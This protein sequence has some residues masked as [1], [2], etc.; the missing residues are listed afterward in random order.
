MM[1]HSW[2]IKDEDG[3]FVVTFDIPGSEVN[4]LNQDNLSELKDIVTSLSENPSVK[5]V[6]FRSAKKKIFIA[7]A[8]IKLIESVRTQDDGFQKAEQG[9][10]VFQ[11]VEN[12]KVPTVAAINGACLGGGYEFALSCGWRVA[13]FSPQVKIGLPEVNLGI[14]PGFGGSIRLPRLLGLAKSLPLILGGRVESAKKALKLGMVDRLF[15]EDELLVKSIRFA[16]DLAD[17]NATPKRFHI[18]KVFLD[19]FILGPLVIYPAARK[20]VLKRTKGHYP[21]PLMALDLIQKTYAGKPEISFQ[22]ESKMF[23]ELAVT[24]ISKN[25]ISLFFLNERYKKRDW[26]KVT[27]AVPEIRQCGVVGAGV[28]GGGIAQLVSFRDISVK[29]TDISEKALTGA[30]T[31]ARRIYDRALKRGKI[32]ADELERKMNL[33]S[34]NGSGP[35]LASSDI[36]IEAV[37]EDMGIKEKIFKEWSEKTGKNTLLA[38]NTS[39]LSIGNMAKVSKHPERVVGLHFFNPV[40]RMPLVEVIRSERTSREALERTIRFARRLGK[41]VIVTKDTPGFLVN[42]L[43]LPYLNEAAFLIEEGVSIKRV[44]RIARSFGM[45]MGPAELIDQV[46]IDVG[47][48]VAHILESAFGDRMK[49]AS[50][51]ETVKVK[52]LLGKKSG[53]GFYLYQGKTKRVNPEIVPVQKTCSPLSDDDILKRLIYIMINEAARCLDEKVIDEASTVDIGLIMGTGFPPFRGGLLRY[54]DLVGANCVVADLN[55][56]LKAAGSDRF[57]PSAYLQNMAKINKSFYWPSKHC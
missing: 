53:R 43:L 36:I 14:L 12:L 11:L 37:V 26:T 33:I 41:M 4:V 49:V 16:R 15:K 35:D 45:P 6:V 10:K 7:G 57:T 3:V 42:R 18:F 19:Q 51:L 47:Y 50:L 9:K 54:A 52:G 24:K 30:V 39:S 1:Q 29:V 32:K 25:L 55:R 23:S 38:S 31:E 5:A 20:N 22:A 27:S 56:F 13:A 40:Y 48:K 28:M 2:Q 44:D 8:D 46:G 34:V 17:R 21:A